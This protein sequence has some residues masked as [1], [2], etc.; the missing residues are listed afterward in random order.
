MRR[1]QAEKSL[2]GTMM[3]PRKTLSDLIILMS[4]GQAYRLTPLIMMKKCKN[5]S[6]AVMRCIYPSKSRAHLIRKCNEKT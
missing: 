6:S 3:M 4:L 1:A 5:L 2:K